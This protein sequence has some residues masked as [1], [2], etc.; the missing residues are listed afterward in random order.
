VDRRSEIQRGVVYRLKKISFGRRMELTRRIRDIAQRAEF[1][2]AG[3]KAEEKIEAAILGQEI[4]RL[5]V[6]WGVE[7]VRGLRVDG[8]VAT[9]EVLIDTGP[10]ELFREALALVRAECGLTESERKN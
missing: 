6:T 9:P 5:Y 8:A 4:E 7:E 10:E 1:L 2:A 3:G